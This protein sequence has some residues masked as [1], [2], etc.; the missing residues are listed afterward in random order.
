[1]E[2]AAIVGGGLAGFVAYVTLRHGRLAP[3]E[4]SVF[5]PSADPAAPWRMRAA[6]IRQRRMRSESDGHCLPTSFPGLAVR[7]ARRRRSA[8][9]LVRTLFDAYHP[10]VEEFLEHVDEVRARCGWDLSLVRRRVE[11]VRAVDGG[12]EL[13]GQGPFRHVL[14]APGP[15]GLALTA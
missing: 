13:D 9:P 11:R 14:L 4:I 5:T 8:A 15:P 6:A 10:T 1:M 3:Q 7:A 2:R 12:F